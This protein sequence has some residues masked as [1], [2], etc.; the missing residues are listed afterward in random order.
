MATY[1]QIV[2]ETDRFTAMDSQG[3]PWTVVEST[4]YQ[5]RIGFVAKPHAPVEISKAYALM[6][7]RALLSRE[8]GEYQTMDGRLRLTR[9]P[10]LALG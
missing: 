8:S 4:T 1:E 7:E 3:R 6:D 9:S 5:V 10:A 2:R